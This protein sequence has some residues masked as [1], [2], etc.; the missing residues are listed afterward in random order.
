[1]SN[2]S[3]SRKSRYRPP[4]LGEPLRGLLVLLERLGWIEVVRGHHNMLTRRATTIRAT[5]R[6]LDSA[7]RFHLGLEDLGLDPSE[8]VII[9]KPRKVRGGDPAHQH[10]DFDDKSGKG[11]LR[12]DDNEVT[13]GYRDKVRRINAWLC[14]A[15]IA[16]YGDD[17]RV[18]LSQRRLRRIFTESFTQGGRLF[19]GFWQQMSKPEREDLYVD[20]S[21]PVEVDYSQ[22]AIRTVYAMAKQPYV[23][24]DAYIV[25]GHK[26]YRKG[27]KKLV[28]AML[29][30]SKP[31]M[32]FP[33]GVREMLP[34]DADLSW[35]IRRIEETHA[36]IRDYFYRGIGLDAMFL[37]SEVMVGVL[38]RLID[39]G[40]VALPIHDAVIVAKRHLEVTTQVMMEVY[41]EHLGVAPV[42]NVGG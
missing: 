31:L 41:K 40:V 19:D 34:K 6:L 35:L 37:E 3:L 32:Q 42:L 24:Q 16:Y 38:L 23:G 27:I 17:D 12:Y 7:A 15:H 28:S 20:G 26:R 14:E 30:S 39:G 33:R 2:K 18:D 10:P 22:M 36:P 11:Y 29:Y 4:V 9:L 5:G 13:C 25:P 21:D 8:E 1:M